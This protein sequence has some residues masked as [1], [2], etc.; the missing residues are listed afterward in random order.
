VALDPIVSLSVA[1]AEA[2][3]SHAFL[4]GSGISREAGVP[5]GEQVLWQAVGE[6]YRLEN[7]TTDTPGRDGLAGWLAESGREGFTYSEILQLIV[8]D[9]ATRRD[10]LAKHFEGKEAGRS[11]HEL[12][13][14]AEAGL[15]RV[16]VTTNF[17]R[18][19]EH[20]LQA[21]GIEP[22]VVTCAADLASA[23]RREH[24][25][26]YVV[27]P[28]GDYLQETIRNTLA[29]LTELEPEMAAELAEIFGR[30]GVV[31]LGYSGS[32]PAISD[33]LGAR[34]SRYGLYWVARGESGEGASRIVER[35][36]G[37]VIRR[38]GAVEF[39]TDLHRRLEV[40]R[41]HPSGHTPIEVHDEVL[42]LV[43]SKDE[44]GLAEVMRRERRE[45]AERINSIV[46]G[47]RQ[48]QPEEENLLEAHDQLLPVWERR[49]AGLLPVLAYAPDRFAPE[50]RSLVD[51]LEGRPVE[52]GYSAWPEF[53]DWSTWWL[54]Y[55]AGAFALSQEAWPALKPLLD[56]RFTEINDYQRHLV[57]PGRGDVSRSVGAL[58]MARFSET[59]WMSPGWEHLIWSVSQSAVLRE[60]WPEFLQG[61]EPKVPALA[62][63]DLLVSMRES[64]AGETAWAYWLIYRGGGVRFARRIRTDPRYRA[65]VSGVLGVAENDFLELVGPALKEH[66]RVAGNGFSSSGAL[67]VLLA[68]Q[69]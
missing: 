67:N 11:H 2:P 39:L 10:Y 47:R 8:P 60:R 3:G 35:T 1:I 24:A 66:A 62:D 25:D 36:G 26:C 45:F 69:V 13:A 29:E 68:D 63:F 27:K 40:F 37:R 38:P 9:P 4:L 58:V 30:Y 61:E 21:R 41:A 54:G 12:A 14:L 20:A 19:L 59:R 53:L 64:L 43:R 32:D 5:T 56:A 55:V 18:L 46:A 51:L 65:A 28:H 49:L 52:G 31:V 48:E 57:E 50:V 7:T 42:A 17:D 34:R 22:V 15:I 23:P 16:F 33:L 6:L 44:I